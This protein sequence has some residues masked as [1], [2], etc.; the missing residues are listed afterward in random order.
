[1]VAQQSP[2][3]VLQEL[4]DDRLLQGDDVYTLLTDDVDSG[5]TRLPVLDQ[6]G[7]KVGMVILIGSGKVMEVRVLIGFGSLVIDRGLENRHPTGTAITGRFRHNDGKHDEGTLRRNDSIM[8]IDKVDLVQIE[9]N[10]NNVDSTEMIQPVEEKVGSVMSEAVE[11]NMRESVSAA[12]KV[13]KQIEAPTAVKEE[14]VVVEAEV[15]EVVETAIEIETPAAE[16]QEEQPAVIIEAEESEDVVDDVAAVIETPAEDIVEVF[17][18]IEAIDAPAAVIE[19]PVV[20]EVVVDEAEVIEAVETAIESETPATKEQEKQP[21]VII[22]AEE[23]EDVVAD[24]AAVIST[25]V[26]GVGK[27]VGDAS[28]SS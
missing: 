17:E 4:L 3:A 25:E 2:A 10:A 26:R 13:S 7:F 19:T 16:E 20:E 9:T 11:T 12:A 14:V 24:V 18:A 28:E 8:E 5:E 23:N 21:A 6:T 1:V 15:G 27:E 22:E